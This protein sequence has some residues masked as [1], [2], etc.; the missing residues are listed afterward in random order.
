MVACA[1][2]GSAGEFA[3]SHHGALTRSQAAENG[4]SS[5][6]V[7]RLLRDGV[8][9]EPAPG[10]LVVVGSVRSWQQEMYVATL[11][12]KG[13]GVAG[14]RSGA[15]IQGLDGYARESVELL[16]PGKRR[17][18]L[19]NLVCHHGPMGPEHSLDF[20]E[21]DGIR[22]TGVARTLCDLGSVD[23]KERVAMAFESAWRNGYS[24][25]WM[26]QTAERL[27]R[28]G[29]R[30]TGVLMRLLDSAETRPTPTESA[31][32]VRVERALSGIPGVVRQFSIFDAKGRFIA[33]TDFAIPELKIAIEAHSR[34]F[35]FGPENEQR[36]S[37][38]EALVQAEGWIVRY[39]THAQTRNRRALR[40]SLLALVSARRAA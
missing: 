5:K 34:R 35:H 21:V 13:A 10:V 28:P 39:V 24:L 12:S 20:T 8:L 14:F 25:T 15:A 33:R 38:R 17:I 26:R 18:L 4:L 2:W 22:C 29:Q 40:S 19:P 11:A 32:E 16:L 1:P 23:P 30:G 37:Q 27:H 31:L 7:R 36:D 9:I 6:D 3:A